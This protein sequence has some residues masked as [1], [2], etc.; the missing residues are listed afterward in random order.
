MTP[1]T[2]ARSARALGCAAGPKE[3]VVKIVVGLVCGVLASAA[4]AGHEVHWSYSGET[5]PEAWAKLAPEFA[6]CAGLN[7]SPID[8]HGFIEAELEPLRLDWKPGGVEILNSGHTA[9]VGY[10]AG[11]TLTVDGIAFELKQFHFHTPSENRV[12]GKSFPMEAHFVHADAEGHLAVLA[13]LFDEGIENPALASLAARLPKEAGEKQALPEA[14]DARAL[15]PAG[16]DYYRFSGSLTTPPCTEGV[17]WLVL[18]QAV[19]ASREQFEK[20]GHAMHAPNAR[21]VQ[22]VNARPV[23]K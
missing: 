22:P 2:L 11:S 18:K 16:R 5:G 14:F 8:L 21:P 10:G 9:Q 20:V 13:L 4:F 6:A 12:E 15:L 17:R 23:L 7:Q 19:P 1:V 3:G